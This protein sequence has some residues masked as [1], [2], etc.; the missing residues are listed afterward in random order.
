MKKSLFLFA[1]A[2]LFA[3]N[4]SAQLAVKPQ[5][6]SFAAVE[7]TALQ[8]TERDAFEMNGPRKA[9]D[10]QVYY[11]RPEGS[12]LPGILED[13]RAYQMSMIYCPA[14][15]QFNLTNMAANKEISEWFFRNNEGNEN[16]YENVDADYNLNFQ[17][18]NYNG[19]YYYI[20]RLRV[21]SVEYAYGESGS[22][23]DRAGMSPDSINYK[24]LCDTQT[25]TLY[26]WGTLKPN[27]YMFGSGYYDVQTEG[28]EGKYYCNGLVQMCPKPMGPMYV[29]RIIVPFMNSNHDPLPN[30]TALTLQIRNIE[31]EER[32]D[33]SIR[34]NPGANILHEFTATAEDLTEIELSSHA[35]QYTE[36]GEYYQYTVKFSNKGT[37]IVGN[38]IDKPFVL[39]DEYCIVILGTAQEGV[40]VGF[41]CNEQNAA[42]NPIYGC[43]ALAYDDQD[44]SYNA[45]YGD[46]F[47]LF[48][49]LYGGFD[50]CEVYETATL[51]D[52]TQLDKLNVLRVSEDGQDIVNEGYAELQNQV[53][54][55]AAYTWLDGATGNPNYTVDFD[56]M[57]EWITALDG[58]DSENGQIAVSIECEALPEGTTGRFAVLTIKGKGYASAAPIYVLQGDATL[59]EAIAASIET[60]TDN[61]KKSAYKGYYNMAGQRVGNDYKGIVISNG[62]K[63]IRK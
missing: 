32:E 51:N 18:S 38:V 40:D 63:E 48:F 49:S 37:D 43:W 61:S 14:F 7:P 27:R 5:M 45:W 6:K 55:D 44:R 26:G 25:S 42:D 47:C 31:Y 21:G 12:L 33:G 19:Y 10:D 23:P 34:R 46:S 59:E 4:A 36:T 11:T 2:S 30:G 3:M 1:V 35:S 17:M 20:P 13:M 16:L 50:Y 60:V 62:K 58:V 28:K 29:E 22:Y 39:N 24:S 57:P 54:M 53:L 56:D 9:Y 15:S 8:A 41:R 52:G